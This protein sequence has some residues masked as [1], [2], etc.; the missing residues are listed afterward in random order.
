MFQ[1]VLFA[2]GNV[3]IFSVHVIERSP[4]PT[5]PCVFLLGR[6][7]ISKIIWCLDAICLRHRTQI[8]CAVLSYSG[9]SYS[10]ECVFILISHLFLYKRSIYYFPVI[11][12]YFFFF[13][14]FLMVKKRKSLVFSFLSFYVHVK[15]HE[16]FFT[17][18]FSMIFYI[19]LL[20]TSTRPQ[21]HSR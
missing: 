21:S 15:M 8:V 10:V 17:L 16:Y 3:M 7:T 2:Y 20:V 1:I 18:W 5:W 11:F 9:C 12:F 19:C 6:N 4:V 14:L 13:I